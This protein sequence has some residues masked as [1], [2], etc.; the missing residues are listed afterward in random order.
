[1]RLLRWAAQ[2]PQTYEKL[3]PIVGATIAAAT[4]AFVHILIIQPDWPV[5]DTLRRIHWLFDG[6]LWQN[7]YG[8]QLAETIITVIVLLIALSLA[9]VAIWLPLWN[10]YL[11]A[12]RSVSEDFTANELYASYVQTILLFA[13]LY[14]G[15]NY[16]SKGSLLGLHEIESVTEYA[17]NQKFADATKWPIK[18]VL[19]SL[20]DCLHFSVVTQTTLGFGDMLPK[21]FT[22]KLLVDIQVLSGVYFIAIAIARKVSQ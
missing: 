22:A 15:L 4:V 6:Q 5:Q 13:L 20:L 7:S 12:R 16:F 17:K 10:L 1:M 2:L 21:S 9:V 11:F 8:V 18:D 14:Y 19:L 3:P